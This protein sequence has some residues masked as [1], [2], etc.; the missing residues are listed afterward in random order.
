[1]QRMSAGLLKT[2][3]AKAMTGT[4]RVWSLRGVAPIDRCHLNCWQDNSRETNYHIKGKYSVE[5]A[6]CKEGM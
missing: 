6:C 2:A 1:M 4:V 3:H 5:E